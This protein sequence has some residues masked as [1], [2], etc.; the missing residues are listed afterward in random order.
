MAKRKLPEFNAAPMADIAFL[1]LIF[2]LVATTMNVDTGILRKLPPYQEEP[3]D[4]PPIK[5]RNVLIVLLNRNNQLM[6]EG[7]IMDISNLAERTK[8]F[9]KNPENKDHLSAKKTVEI[10]YFGERKVSKGVVSLQND[11]GT[12]YGE[13]LKVQNELMKAYTEL[14]NEVSMNQFGK[15]YEELS[16]DQ[17]KAVRKIYPL[18]ISEAEPKNVGGN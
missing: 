4:T 8:N 2:F 7:E 12:K 14:R 13:Y 16:S 1:L 10:S 11:R 6:V 17:K 5:E 18:S 9:I 15:K 3:E